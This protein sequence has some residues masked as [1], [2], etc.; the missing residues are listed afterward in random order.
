M[1]TFRRFAVATLWAALV[2]GHGAATAPP[3]ILWIMS[4]DLGYGE[5]GVF[6]QTLF[7]TPNIDKLAAEGLR[8]TNAYT[9]QA[10][11]APSRTSLMTGLHQG[12][13]YIRGNNANADGTDMALRSNDTTVAE[14]LQAA[15][16]FTAHVGKWGL[17]YN[18]ST[19]AP[20]S[21]GFDVRRPARARA[22]SFSRDRSRA[23]ARCSLST[24]RRVERLTGAARAALAPRL[25]SSIGR[26]VVAREPHAAI[27]SPR[28]P[29]VPALL[30]LLRAVLLRRARPGSSSRR[31]I[32][33]GVAPLNNNTNLES[34]SHGGFA[35][36]RTQAN[37]HNM[38][39]QHLWD[40][41]SQ[42]PLVGNVPAP[43][44]GN[45]FPV[46]ANLLFSSVGGSVV[47][48]RAG[49]SLQLR[50]APA[51]RRRRRRC[52]A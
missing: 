34:P 44:D 5:L 39:P 21:K 14:L 38:Y 36:A 35:A 40:G 45:P 9:G 19:G 2:V 4:D 15:G 20:L 24:S 17:G 43:L 26:F 30:F 16:Y 52:R 48:W 22:L 11:C 42:F 7:A 23:R 8:F 25:T 3:N 49:A 32:T 1:A 50:V 18:G 31:V 33:S 41:E 29:S 51:G 37:A 12:H 10:V 47:E 6:G 27:S 46:G 13:A 28:R